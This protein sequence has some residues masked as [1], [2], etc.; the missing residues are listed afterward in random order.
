MWRGGFVSKIEESLFEITTEGGVELAFA[1][2]EHNQCAIVRN[3]E[4]ERVFGPDA[5]VGLAVRMYF[6][7][8]EECGGARHPF[9]CVEPEGLH[10]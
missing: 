9:Q 2:L 3:G 5:D 6:R 4:I 1:V 8:V 10:N 7:R